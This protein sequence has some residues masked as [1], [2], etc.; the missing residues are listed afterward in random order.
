MLRLIIVLLL[1]C[2]LAFAAVCSTFG[3]A[4]FTNVIGNQNSALCFFNSQTVASTNQYTLSAMCKMFVSYCAPTTSLVWINTAS[5][6]GSCIALNL[7][8]C[9][10]TTLPCFSA[11]PGACQEIPILGT[12]PYTVV[13]TITSTTPQTLTFSSPTIVVLTS[14]LPATATQTTLV[15]STLTGFDTKMSTTSFSLFVT[16]TESVVTLTTSLMMTTVSITSPLILVSTESE[17]TQVTNSLV[18]LI[19][20]AS[21]VTTVY[22]FTVST[23]FS[24]AFVTSTQTRTKSKTVTRATTT[25]TSTST[26]VSLV[27][28]MSTT[29]PC[30]TQTNYTKLTLTV[31]SSTTVTDTQTTSASC[32]PMVLPDCPGP[33]VQCPHRHDGF[34]MI[35]NSVPRAQ[36]DCIC[37]RIRKQLANIV[38]GGKQ[39]VAGV[40][41]EQCLGVDK[42]A[43]IAEYEGLKDECLVV[44]SDG[45]TGVIGRANPCQG[46]SL[47]VLCN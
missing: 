4:L 19:S 34:V 47:P 26:S 37:K 5:V 30:S 40:M 36:A 7:G 44:K 43:W 20:L 6:A 24:C 12:S 45:N 18:T 32:S 11:L 23:L 17:A 9:T 29:G 33:L 41:A 15:E 1:S 13:L 42:M 21:S 14:T 39:L 16:A 31:S 3:F 22:N 28:L 8:A 27:I 2:K 10:S 25:Q 46:V 35:V 38:D